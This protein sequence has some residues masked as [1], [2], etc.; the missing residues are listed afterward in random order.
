MPPKNAAEPER[1]AWFSDRRFKKADLHCHSVYSTFKYFRIAN[2]RDSYNRPE[3]VYRLAKQR[4]MDYVTLTDHD[5]IDGCLYLLN[6]HPDLD[7]FFISEEVET[8]FPDTR[9]RIH[10]NVFG[11]DERQHAEIQKRREN[12]YDLHAYLREEKILASANHMFQNYRMRNSPRQYFEEMLRMFDVFEVKNGAMASQHNRL[13]EDLMAVVR[14]KRGDVSLVAGSDAHTLGPL[15]RVYTVAEAETTSEF[16][17]K[18]R[19]GQCFVWGAEMG[20]RVLLSDVYRMVF[21]YYGSVLDLKN[22]EFTRGAKARHLALAAMGAPITAAGVPL[23]ITSLNY[24]KQIFVTRKI[25][26]ALMSHLG[27]EKPS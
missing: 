19:Q 24:V 3:D 17:E 15:A 20:F 10:V 2:T 13:V 6:K 9:Q 11:I 26:Q 4:G 18:V 5:S 16:L 21:R 7:D 27:D 25:G 12:I 14:E 1:P 22:P 8:W 23:A